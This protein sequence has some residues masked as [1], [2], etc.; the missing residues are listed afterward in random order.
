MDNLR[1]RTL[2]NEISCTGIGLHTGEKI[3]LTLR[4]AP[5]DNGISFVR[6]DISGAPEVKAVLDNVVHTRLATTLGK[7]G[8]VIGTVEHLLSA[9][10][11][12]GV[13]NARIEL[14]GPEVPIMDGS[15]AP[16]VF[17][18]KTAGLRLQSKNKKFY[19]IRKPVSLSDGEK[20]VAVLPDRDFSINY[21]INFDHPLVQTQSLNFRFSVAAF[22][23]EISR[24]RTFGFLHEVEYLKKNGFARGGSL[25]NAVVVDRFRVLNQDGLRYHDEFIRHKILDFIGDISLFGAPIIGRFVA[26][27]AGHTLNHRLLTEIRANPSACELVELSH[28]V[29]REPQGGHLQA[30]EVL[31]PVA[32][33]V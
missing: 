18:L 33:A 30:W 9:L 15:A 24:A 6:A 13:D 14:D 29:Q 4:P 12:F 31:G 16:F 1:Q 23:K 26:V 22:E 20:R 19:V 11:G 17:L 10:S 7:N 21:T 25:A 2:K 28:P 8:V 27:K 3:R 5:E 32:A